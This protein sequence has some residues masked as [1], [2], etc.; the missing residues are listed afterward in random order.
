M[1]KFE[2]AFAAQ[3][4]CRHAI[5]LISGTSALHVALA[6]LKELHGWR[7]GDEVLVPASTFIASSNVV[8]HNGLRPVFVDI[9]P[10][11]YNL[12]PDRIAQHVT[13]RTRAIMPVHLYGQPCD[14]DRIMSIARQLNLKAIEDSC[15]C[16]FAKFD[17]KA[18]GSFGDMACFSTYVAHIMTTGVGGLITT[19]NDHYAIACRSVM[20]HGRDSIYLNI[21]DD[22]VGDAEKLRAIVSRRFNF[23]RLGHSFRSTELE[24]A[25]GLGQLEQ[26]P[27]IMR[28]RRRNAQ[29]LTATLKPFEEWLQI[30]YIA[31]RRDHSFMMYPIVCKKGTNRED[32]VNHL[33]QCGIET[34]YMM[35]LLS[36][37]IYKQLF[38]DDLEDNYPVAKWVTTNG[39]YLPCHH[40]MNEE[41]IEYIVQTIRDFL[42]QSTMGH[43]QS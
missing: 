23:V 3:H 13:D 22:N 40:G 36:Q 38:G 43:S 20:A 19:N 37:P 18:V 29:I 28:L 8:L 30:P 6:V 17:G 27:D 25:L 21:D 7:D 9:D 26:A 15:E 32:L 1:E 14:M 41:D 24:A 11:T 39:F 42:R 12:D 16:M 31:P 4:D 33:E 34:R 5:M 35:P 2:S 10:H